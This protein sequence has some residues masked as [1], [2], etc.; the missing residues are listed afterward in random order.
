MQV[1]P[2]LVEVLRWYD[3][4]LLVS[5]WKNN[6]ST[7]TSV[8]S[9]GASLSFLYSLTHA[10]KLSSLL[11]DPPDNWQVWLI[12]CLQNTLK[13]SYWVQMG[14][15]NCWYMKILIYYWSLKIGLSFF[16]YVINFGGYT[17][18][19]TTR[20]SFILCQL[21][22]LNKWRYWIHQKVVLHNLSDS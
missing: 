11:N 7:E 20:Q 2:G 10:A 5:Y 16:F 8:R 12:P 14:I 3:M 19:K 18:A 22:T 13:S 21:I 17:T 4:S 1:F 9:Y 6:L 15:I